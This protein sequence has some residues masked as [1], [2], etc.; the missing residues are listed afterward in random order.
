VLKGQ[1]KEKLIA[2][3][4]IIFFLLMICPAI[5]MA[6]D[7]VVS[8]TVSDDMGPMMGVQVCEIDGQKRIIEATT[9]DM[10]GNF[11]LKVRN[12]KNKIRFSYVGMKMQTLP[13]GDQSTYNIVLEST[14]QLKEVVVTSNNR[15]ATGGLAIPMKEQTLAQ[16]TISTKEFEGLSFTSIDEALQGRISGLAILQ[17]SGNLGSGTT[18]RLRGVSSIYGNAEPLIVV[19]GNIF[20]T[21]ANSDI[22]YSSMT[23]EKFSELL[24]INP[25]DIESIT[26]LKD[27]A[28]T[29][30]WGSRGSN[31]VISIVTKRGRRGKPRI[32]YS[33]KLRGTYQPKGFNML[34][35]DEYTMLMK[36]E[37]FNTTQNPDVQEML[38]YN[39]NYSEYQQY[40]NNTDW[41]KAV[42]QFGLFQTHYLSISGGGEKA[43]YRISGGWDHQKGSVIAQQ[44]DRLSTRMALDY[45]VNTR[46]KISSNFALTYTKN[47][48]NSDNLLSIAYQKMPNMAIY[49]EDVNGNSLGTYYKMPQ[50][51]AAY[52]GDVDEM[53]AQRKLVNP[54]ASAYLAKKDARSY[55]VVPQFDI[56]YKFL[57]TDEERTQLN[58]TGTVVLSILNSYN[59]G[60]YPWELLSTD[61]K[62]TEG[63][64][65]SA[66]S[67]FSKS[68]GFTTRHQLVFIPKFNNKD[69]SVRMLLRGEYNSGYSS[70]QNITSYLLPS[71]TITSALAGGYLS[72]TTTGSGQ[73]RSANW[74]FQTH[75][76]FREKYSIDASVRG[77]GSTRFGP[78]HRWGLFYSISGRWNITDEAFMQKIKEK[79]LSLFAF[80]AGW[81]VTGNQPGSGDTYYSIYSTNGKYINTIGM[82]P[83][84]VRLTDLRWEKLSSWNIGWDIG[85]FNNLITADIN[86][87]S[88]L[89]TDLL[90]RN[91]SI[92]TSSGFKTLAYENGGSMKNVGYEINL[93]LNRLKLAKDFGMAVNFTFANNKNTIIE[94]DDIRLA[95][96]NGTGTKKPANGYYI[97]RVMLNNP[98]GAIYGLRYKGVYAY[99]YDNYEKAIAN[100]ATAPIVYDKDGNVVYNADGTPKQMYYDYSGT[101]Y[102]FSGG[103][104][105]YEDINHDGSIDEYDVV[106]LG[107]SLPKLTGGF[108]LKFY[109][110]DWSLNAQF[111]Y[112][113]GNKIINMARANAENMY[114]SYNQSTAVNYRWRKEGDGANGERIL[115][116]AL[117][118]SGYNWMG[119]DRFVED[120][121]FL[122]LNYLQLS[123]S[124]NKNLL[125]KIG[126]SR[127]SIYVSADNLFCIT[128][129]TGVDPEVTYG[130]M[131]VT[132][133]NATTPRARSYTFGLTVDF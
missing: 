3:R 106:Y 11:S 9:T 59:D 102:A 110:K 118:G 5:V 60:Y 64:V 78:S 41:R 107:S 123:Y 38:E 68:F 16:Q 99:S 14:T 132:T 13:I 31:G 121:S 71:G 94:M 27:A 108:G 25:E 72:T 75:Y 90:M 104:A 95:S 15:V 67:A 61:W 45:F 97:T 49:D 42:T 33:L 26:V 7:K 10:N 76:S 53:A 126:L 70:S 96:I 29:A 98:F 87:Y 35:G 91:P 73:W 86:L 43:N 55:N 21:D 28:A 12:P 52:N 100:G 80:R 127:M 2:M 117:Y 74:V 54:V 4:Q 120:G 8:G 119:S 111:N 40:N 46:I 23:D 1:R 131:G 77:D 88:Q 51:E 93:N 50:F 57:G 83:T 129:Y 82:R 62:Q 133:D 79:W 122:R 116:R 115:P 48:Q 20:E 84:N 92:P 112:R 109:Y 69:H 113:Y 44:L 37:L 17:N 32:S 105:I 85:L 36:E 34:S 128:K 56:Q 89:K 65:N 30:I 103:D 101:K 58:Y 125:K 18:M 81:G 66:S 19:D 22:D 114:S 130:S 124:L 47:Q 63:S 24:S 39:T 6:Q